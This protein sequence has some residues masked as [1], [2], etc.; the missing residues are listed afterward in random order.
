[1]YQ[2]IPSLTI[3]RE[4][5]EKANSPPPLGHEGSAKPQF[6]GRKIVLKPPPRGQ[7]FSKIQQRNTK[8][9][10]EIMKNSTE[11]LMCLEILKQ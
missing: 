7:L 11:T 6:W 4:F 5:F 10:I 1:M 8:H 3:P 9:E 2:S